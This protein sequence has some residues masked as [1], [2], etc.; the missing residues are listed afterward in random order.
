[1]LRSHESD[2]IELTT[3]IGCVDVGSAIVWRIA[4]AIIR[5]DTTV[6]T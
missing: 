1:M 2:P 3:A 4:C 5:K 6:V